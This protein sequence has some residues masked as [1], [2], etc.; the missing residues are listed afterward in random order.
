MPLIVSFFAPAFHE[1]DPPGVVQLY[2][3]PGVRFCADPP[4]AELSSV[5]FVSNTGTVPL[6]VAHG[7]HGPGDENRYQKSI[8]VD[9]SVGAR[10]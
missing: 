1:I 2:E 10:A 8:C 9:E 7:K 4:P 3:V 6:E 5:V